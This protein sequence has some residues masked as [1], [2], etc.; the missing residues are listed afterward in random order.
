MSPA[1]T[2]LGLAADDPHTVVVVRW[3]SLLQPGWLA[4]T[5]VVFGFAV[6]CYTVLAPWQFDRHAERKA[7][8]DAVSTSF[9]E[10]PRPLQ[11]VLPE[12]RAPGPDTEWRRVVVEGTYLPEH[13]IIAR[14]RTVQ[15]QP[16]F[17]VLTPLRTTDGRIVV[18]DRGYLRPDNGDVPPYAAPP[19]GTVRVEARVRGDETD[20]QGRDAFSDESTQ[21]RLHAYTIDSRTVARAS[22][23]DVSPGY[24]QLTEG[25]PGVLGALP[26]PKLEAGPY[27]S[28]ALQ[29][30]AF[31]TMAVLAWGYFTVRELKPGGA[32]S[33]ES[34]RPRRKSVAEL[35]AE[36]EEA[37]RASSDAEHDASQTVVGS[38][39]P[40]DDSRP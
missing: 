6:T 14:L 13:E 1:R 34:Q 17:E 32:L 15:G 23:L 7:Q 25:Q 29:W 26:L 36:D 3:K 30:V 40:A 31:G 18:I 16:A 12:G 21:G 28:Y 10:Q 37:E 9:S 39:S 5:F 4:L 24:L 20:P 19:G 35:L 27:F 11:E 2:P 38:R 22:G 33:A 8:N